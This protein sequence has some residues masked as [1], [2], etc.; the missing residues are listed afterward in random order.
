MSRKKIFTV[1]IVPAAGYGKRLKMRTK[2]PLISLK[3]RPIIAHTLGALEKCK[4][5]NAVIV[6]AEKRCVGTFKGIVKKY[7]F[8]KV[9]GVVAGGKERFD[10][11]KNCLRLIE[12]SCDIVLIHD[13][14]RPLIEPALISRSVKLAER[15]GACI[16][17]VPESDTVK[18]ADKRSFIYGTLDRNCVYRAQTPQAFRYGLIKKAYGGGNVKGATDDASL[19]EAM[20]YRVKILKGSYRNIKITT[21]EDLKIA[22]ALI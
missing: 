15:Y 17:A 3:G 22:E 18:I 20:G 12:P 8:R 19:A 6:A 13:G 4:D 11:V 14:A 21:R 16:V 2:K 5:V 9:V 10:S 7:G 1:A